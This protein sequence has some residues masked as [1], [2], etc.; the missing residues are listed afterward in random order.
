MKVASHSAPAA[1]VTSGEISALN[2]IRALAVSLV[3]FAHGGLEHLVPGGLGVTLFFVLSGYLITTLMQREYSTTG[4]LALTA[5][6][7]RRIVRLMPPLMVVVALTALLASLN[8]IDG[9]F[10]PRGLL[11]VLFYFGNYHVIAY[12]FSGMPAGM[13]VVWS[14]AV[15]E[16]YYLLYPPLASLLLSLRRPKIAALVLVSLCSAIFGWR[17]WLAVQGVS[18]NYISMATDTRADAILAGCLMAFVS[19]PV[20]QPV[21]A[22]RLP[23]DLLI[24]LGSLLLLLATLLYRDELFRLTL[25]YTLQSVAVALLIRLAIVHAAKP[26]LRWLSSRPLV[27]LGT[28]SYTVY[29]SHQIILNGVQR[30]WPELDWTA[31]LMLTALL[32]LAVAE[33]MR[34]WVEQP[35]VRLRRYLTPGRRQRSPQPQ[36]IPSVAQ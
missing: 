7:L 19:N 4:T 16:H 34:R 11:S 22:P 27:Y 30:H 1:A 25:R 13:G 9:D 8:L 17:C 3:F 35:S 10:S 18:E 5:F 33:P 6:Y 26:S 15:E 23:R 32:T 36:P 20:M 29:L 28:V 12:D 31:T 2:G 14:L 24:G 21:A